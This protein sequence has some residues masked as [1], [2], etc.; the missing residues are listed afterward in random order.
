M[1]CVVAGGGRISLNKEMRCGKRFQAERSKSIVF[2][3]YHQQ[4]NMESLESSS[5]GLG[6]KVC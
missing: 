4:L 1:L 2:M 6:S 3:V 5:L